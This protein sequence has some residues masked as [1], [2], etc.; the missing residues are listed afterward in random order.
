MVATFRGAGGFATN[1]ARYYFLP[2]HPALSPDGGEGG[3]RGL[4]L[5]TVQILIAKADCQHKNCDVPEPL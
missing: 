2:P 4:T 5:Q 1:L 3:V